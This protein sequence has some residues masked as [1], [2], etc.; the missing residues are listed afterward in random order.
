M[1]HSE[2]RTENLVGH[3]GLYAHSPDS[4]SSTA[5]VRSNTSRMPGLPTLALVKMRLRS[6]ELYLPV[7][8][9]GVKGGCG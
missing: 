6:R 8:Q 3:S 2:K 9:A 5:L 4:A 1:G 7:G